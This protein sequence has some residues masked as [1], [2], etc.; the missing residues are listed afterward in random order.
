MWQFKCGNIF[1]TTE[2]L[3]IARK[4]TAGQTVALH[5]PCC[6]ARGD[7]VIYKMLLRLHLYQRQGNRRGPR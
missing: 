6:C 2:R 7:I 3:L 5:N 4:S 1:T